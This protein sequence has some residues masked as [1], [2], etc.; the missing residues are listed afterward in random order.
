MK[1]NIIGTS[2]SGKTTFGKKL[3]EILDIP[4]LELDAIFW[5][6]DWIFPQD[7]ELFPRLSAALEEENWVLDGNYSRTMAI[8]WEHVDIVIWL[9]YSFLRTVFQAFNRAITRI[10]TQEELWPGTGNRE[11]L[12]KL[13]SRQSILLWTITT[14]ARKRTKITKYLTA[15]EYSHIIFIR[16]KS[17]SKAN[18]LLKKIKLNPEILGEI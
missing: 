18:H 10:I 8:K 3:A 17:P 4:F 5:G 11:T 1:I 2:G 15:D 14:Y 7:D 12:R 6:S 16:L 9:D 13:F